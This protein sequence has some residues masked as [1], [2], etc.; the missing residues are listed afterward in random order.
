MSGGAAVDPA[1]G[2]TGA[3]GQLSVT[4]TLGG[5]AGRYQILATTRDKR[6]RDVSC[7]LRESHSDTNR[8]WAD[9]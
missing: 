7:H 3:D 8:I 1:E 6:G 5:V 2:L 9:S 4:V